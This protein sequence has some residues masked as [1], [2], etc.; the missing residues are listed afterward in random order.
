MA[1]ALNLRPTGHRVV[2][3]KSGTTNGSAEYLFDRLWER[4]FKLKTQTWF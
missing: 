1:S 2:V 4:M 3:I